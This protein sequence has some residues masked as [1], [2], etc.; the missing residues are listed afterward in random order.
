LPEL[1]FEPVPLMEAYDLV[2]RLLPGARRVRWRL[3]DKVRTP[4]PSG[5]LGNAAGVR[6]RAGELAGEDLGEEP[7][8]GE[9][10]L[11]GGLGDG[12]VEEAWPAGA[13]ALLASCR[14]ESCLGEKAQVQT[15]GVSVQTGPAGK[16]TGIKRRLG[17]LK[18]L[19]DPH[20]A[21][22][23][24]GTVECSVGLGSGLI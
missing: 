4:R 5:F 10:L 3:L 2:E 11:V 22:I 13:A 15:N 20:T 14:H 18:Q 7:V 12:M 21:R 19:E 24:Q 16:L 17:L 1:G 8:A 9:R 23:A 6:V